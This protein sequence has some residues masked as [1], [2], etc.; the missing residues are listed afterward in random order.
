MK[1]FVSAW[2]QGKFDYFY[3]INIHLKINYSCN[4]QQNPKPGR[5]S[6]GN[7]NCSGKEG[8]MVR[9][10]WGDIRSGWGG[11]KSLRWL[12]FASCS[13]GYRAS[14]ILLIN[15]ET[16]LN[17]YNSIG[18]WLILQNGTVKWRSHYCAIR[19]Y[20]E[21]KRKYQDGLH[22]FGKYAWYW[23]L[24]KV[25][26]EVHSSASVAFRHDHYWA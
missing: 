17:H 13:G 15:W 14:I 8:E 5:P 2:A 12:A 22:C 16:E 4:R 23:Q 11:R 9:E 19:G 20:R 26:S 7:Y 1:K 25:L 6:W 24:K 18:I 10:G 3:Q 21:W